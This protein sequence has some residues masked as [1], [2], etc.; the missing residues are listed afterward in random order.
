[1]SRFWSCLATQVGKSIVR[2]RSPV[3]NATNTLSVTQLIDAPEAE[4]RNADAEQ[5]YEDFTPYTWELEAQAAYDEWAEAEAEQAHRAEHFTHIAR[6]D[7]QLATHTVRYP[8]HKYLVDGLFP[9][10]EI[11]VIT[12]ESGVG[13]TS[14]LFDFIDD[15]QHE[16]PVLNR[17]SHW[18]PFCILVNDRSQAG[19]QRTLE[20]LDK[21][22]DA[23][24]I[25]TFKQ[26]TKDSHRQPGIKPPTI[27]DKIAAVLNSDKSLRVV[28]VEGLQVEADD[29]NDYGAMS[30]MM[31]GLNALCRERDVTIVATTHTSKVN[32]ATGGA[33]RTA[34]I[35][36]A[37]TPAMCETV[38]VF[39]EA[40]K[41]PGYVLLTVQNH[42]GP[43]EEHFYR[44]TDKGR[45][46]GPV[47][48]PMKKDLL[49][50][51]LDSLPEAVEEIE[52]QLVIKFFV[53][54]ESNEK[55]ADKKLGEAV[56]AEL[57]LRVG[58]G[59]YRILKR[60]EGW[61]AVTF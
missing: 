46:E 44:F 47:V 39:T 37:A 51:Y 58:G 28:F 22:P 41:L 45:L 9:T 55:A 10:K 25:L 43:K 29:G 34:I 14:W 31:A 12:G 49:A 15:W 24:R 23:Y 42:N 20:R 38:L 35:G 56:A 6:C 2:W 13:K 50:K 3:A 16:R 36:S 32:A 18:Q 57:L 30:R 5:C 1:M 52:R 26:S 19:M 54:N 48:P 8:K 60:P 4:L 21:H 33:R 11:H 61:Q 17:A 59:K 27:A 53:D 40:P 7:A